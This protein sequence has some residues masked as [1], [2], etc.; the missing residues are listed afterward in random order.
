MD[1]R[2]LALAVANEVGRSGEI[3]WLRGLG[4]QIATDPGVCNAWSIKPLLNVRADHA[5]VSPL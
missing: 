5:V 3:A 2:A 1:D 4:V